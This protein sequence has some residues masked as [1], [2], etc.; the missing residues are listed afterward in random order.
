MVTNPDLNRQPTRRV[1][2]LGASNVTR[3]LRT[4][5][6]TAARIWGQPLDI[7]AAIGYGRS[8]GKPSRVLARTLPGIKGCEM[9]EEWQA[10]DPLPTAALITDIGN[11][12]LYGAEPQL[13]SRWVRVCA[14]RL[15]ER[16]QTVVITALPLC[17]VD[18]LGP[19]RFKF[20]RS[21]LFP[22]SSLTL[23]QVV[24]SSYE[25]DERV[26]EIAKALN[27]GRTQPDPRWYGIDPIHVR[28]SYW[29][30]AWEQHLLPWR[31]TT[32]ESHSSQRESENNPTWRLT[33]LRPKHQW[34]FGIEQR[35]PQPAWTGPDGSRLS[36][37]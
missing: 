11:D 15:A 2:V 9:W 19:R 34:Y 22:S 36:L 27:L 14:E 7:L 35:R 13:I 32:A 3:G 6:E 12:I 31:G 1:I 25:L 16:C 8:Y 30:D 4:F 29:Q 33:R 28:R 26:A 17:T 37:Y 18:L 10:R 23:Q 24:E 5:C 20:L 21:I